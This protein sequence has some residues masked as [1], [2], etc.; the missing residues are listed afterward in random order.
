V[1]GETRSTGARVAHWDGAYATKGST[2]VSWYEPEP[3]VSLALV[4]ALGVPRDARFVDVGGGASLLVDRLFERGFTDVTVLDVSST[5]L[6]E[7]EDRL[8]DAPVRL[9]L[10]D[11]L[12]WRPDRRYEVWHDRA[13][14]HFLVRESDRDAYRATLRAALGRDGLVVVGAFAEDG[15]KTCSGLRVSRYSAEALRD[16]LGLELLDARRELHTTPGG[17][18]QPFTWIAGRLG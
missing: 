9:I 14:F 2:R 16:A 6:A 13:V 11:V 15:P 12:S 1:A 3:V 4:D 8:G 7:V 17:A 5:A 10:V 18:I